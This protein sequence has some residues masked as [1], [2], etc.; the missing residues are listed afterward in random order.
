MNP[1]DSIFS[2]DNGARDE[3]TGDLVVRS[4]AKINLFLRVGDIDPHGFH[5]LV[6]WM[7]TTSLADT[8]TFSLSRSDQLSI[9]LT[10]D[11]PTI[12]TD[13]TN[14]V[15]RA[16][17]LFFSHDDLSDA[18][19]KTAIRVAI[20]KSI[21]A[22][23]GLGGGSSNAAVTL[24][25]LQKIFR[26]EID[27][28]P[29]AVRLGSDVPFFLEGASQLAQ[30]RG[31]LLSPA[32]KPESAPWAVLML[33][34]KLAVNTGACYRRLDELRREI[35]PIASQNTLDQPDITALSKLGPAELMNE[36]FNDL[37]APAFTIVP[38]L[39]ELRKQ[40]ERLVGR[41]VRMTGSG[42][43][44]FTLAADQHDAR[45]IESR[46][47]ANL[48]ANFE[49]VRTCVVRLAAD[50]IVVEWPPESALQQSAGPILSQEATC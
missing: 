15:S 6:S 8:L 21:P 7:V 47:H 26:T 24:V 18:A 16:I 48:P 13:E 41:V 12:P 23:G 50:A 32:P 2:R 22:G 44:L 4:F 19:R 39:G 20:K 42:S 43:T 34:S 33:P 45:D 46:L 36:L 30:G 9:E 31:E 28:H 1:A 37:E 14:L 5:P 25:T 17:R 49:Q 40:M 27:L 10:C 35:R 3:V 11:D 38:E 29:L